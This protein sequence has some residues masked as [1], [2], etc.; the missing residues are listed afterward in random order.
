V[1]H[2]NIVRA[3]T[4]RGEV[5]VGT[6]SEFRYGI[7][8][9]RHCGADATLMDHPSPRT[10]ARSAMTLRRA[11]RFAPHAHFPTRPPAYSGKR[12]ARSRDIGRAETERGAVMVG[13]ESEFR[14]GIFG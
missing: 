4:E 2:R 12:Q 7:F 13:T 9:E 10:R 11:S 1:R 3:E 5:V 14:Y 8:G 6:E